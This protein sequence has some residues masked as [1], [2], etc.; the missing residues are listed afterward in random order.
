M[1][2]TGAEFKK[3]LFKSSDEELVERLKSLR[4]I[5]ET[6]SI[7]TEMT[8]RLIIVI[9]EFNKNSSK[10]TKKMINLT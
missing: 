2:K 4:P 3:S 9:K 7:K 1:E 5:S 6:E 10:Q 8:R